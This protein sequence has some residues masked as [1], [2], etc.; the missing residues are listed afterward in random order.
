MISG[1]N[2]TKL[3]SLSPLV[4]QRKLTRLTLAIFFSILSYLAVSAVNITT[5]NDTTTLSITVKGIQYVILY[6]QRKMAQNGAYA[7]A[8]S[9]RVSKLRRYSQYRGF[10]ICV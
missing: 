8:R 7:G 3:S 9:C 6:T 10:Y 2:V 4:R 5:L 1:P